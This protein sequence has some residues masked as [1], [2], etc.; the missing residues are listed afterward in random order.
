MLARGPQALNELGRRAKEYCR[1]RFVA[2]VVY[3]QLLARTTAEL[4]QR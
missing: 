3:R 4:T 2:E 1:T